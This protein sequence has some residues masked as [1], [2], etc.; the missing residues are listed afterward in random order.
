MEPLFR[1]LLRRLLRS[2]ALQR[3]VTLSLAPIPR[4]PRKAALPINVAPL[5]HL[6]LHPWE[7]LGIPV[8]KR[9]LRREERARS[10][11]PLIRCVG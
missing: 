3:A 7:A 11:A 9:L 10:A 8:P 6:M 4:K 5:L 1:D 2:Q